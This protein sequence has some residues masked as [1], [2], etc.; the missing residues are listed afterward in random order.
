MIDKSRKK[1]NISAKVKPDNKKANISAKVKPDNK[2]ANISAK[3]KPD[4]KKANISAKIK[5]G[6]NISAKVKYNTVTQYKNEPI[7]E[8]D[9]K[10]NHADRVKYKLLAGFDV[11]ATINK[12][13]IHMILIFTFNFYS[14]I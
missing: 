11:N 8:D 1:A 10:S 12:V 13:I 4:S 9:I 6:S 5:P 3:L 14:F 2:K 7:T